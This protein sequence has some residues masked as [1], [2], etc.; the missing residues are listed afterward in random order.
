MRKKT[1]PF[2]PVDS[3]KLTRDCT[4]RHPNHEYRFQLNGKP[5]FW[6]SWCSICEQ[7][8]WGDDKDGLGANPEMSLEYLAECQGQAEADERLRLEQAANRREK[9]AA[10][11]RSV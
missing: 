9:R 10:R 7:N 4:A 8:K 6:S 1:L 3:A 11:I 2:V 5:F